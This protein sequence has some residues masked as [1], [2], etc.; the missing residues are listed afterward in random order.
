MHPSLDKIL[1]PDVVT[2]I[3]KDAVKLEASRRGLMP[4][5]LQQQLAAYQEADAKLKAD[6]L[7][8]E[9]TL[10]RAKIAR[11]K[12]NNGLEQHGGGVKEMIKEVEAMSDAELAEAA[13]A[14]GDA[15]RPHMPAYSSFVEHCN[16]IVHRALAEDKGLKINPDGTK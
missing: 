5:K 7:F 1:P 14:Q 10:V 8:V 15:L 16:R 12:Y 6:L 9:A 11:N 3:E 4:F 13:T 2:G